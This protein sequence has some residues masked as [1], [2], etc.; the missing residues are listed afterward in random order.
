MRW[1]DIPWGNRKQVGAMQNSAHIELPDGTS[2]IIWSPEPGAEYWDINL[3]APNG[4]TLIRVWDGIDELQARCIFHALTHGA[5]LR[6][7]LS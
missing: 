1:D 4:Q 5:L 2:F 7:A 3:Y 6:R